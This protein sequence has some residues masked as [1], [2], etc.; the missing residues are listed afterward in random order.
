MLRGEPAPG[1]ETV[2]YVYHG[3][4]QGGKPARERAVVVLIARLEAAAVQVKYYG[5]PL[6]PAKFADIEAA[7]RGIGTIVHYIRYHAELHARKFC[8][9]P[10]VLAALVAKIYPLKK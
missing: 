10:P 6:R 4:A 8:A 7:D 5:Q 1:R 9:P 3:V 2:V